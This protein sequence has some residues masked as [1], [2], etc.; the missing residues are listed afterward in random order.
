M[1]LEE[2][3]KERLGFPT[4]DNLQYMALLPS[5]NELGRIICGFAN[6][7]G[8]LLLL[9][10]QNK[11]NI[12]RPVGFSRGFK[13]KNV[14]ESS[15]SKIIPANLYIEHDYI[16][17]NGTVLYAIK[18]HKATVPVAYD[19]ES[20]FFSRGTLTKQVLKSK[21]HMIEAVANFEFDKLNAV[22]RFICENKDQRN[23]MIDS[24]SL[25][26]ILGNAITTAESDL[27]IHILRGSGLVT[28]T[29]QYIG[30]SP[31]LE[32]FLNNGG[33]TKSNNIS[34]L[35]NIPSVFISYNWKTKDAAIKL[36][37]ILT[38]RG[39]KV[40][41][42][43]QDM[44]YK[45]RISTFMESI[46]GNDFAVLMISDPYLK[47]YNCMVEVQHVLRDRNYSIKILP[48]LDDSVHIFKAS[49]R[50]NYVRYW[51]N[52]EKKLK[53]DTD[54]INPTLIIEEL[55]KLRQAELITR[56]INDFLSELSNMLL[57]KISD[58]EKTD[59][60]ALISYITANLP[61]G[62]SIPL[63]NR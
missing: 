26:S 7:N 33:F 11:N 42:D 53:Q 51:E 60:N 16:P 22:L 32:K 41:R 59:Y 58:E 56:G 49:D 62:K 17:Y 61:D 34:V 43:D 28:I 45:D 29:G 3:V 30:Y 54:G 2:S 37:E 9:G 12:I 57:R 1:T 36:E 18:V 47:S 10:V 40:S 35:S 8:G 15:V 6:T 46:R 4:S 44:S 13:V 63:A 5:G 21:D 20:Y 27:I 50:L 23:G 52:E 31:G 55:K 25:K 38:S 39:F 48:V 24:M 19:G 14:L